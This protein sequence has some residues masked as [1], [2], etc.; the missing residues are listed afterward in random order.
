M[1]SYL[2]PEARTGEQM[3]DSMLLSIL[4]RLE[5]Q[6]LGSEGSELAADRETAQDYFF[7]RAVGRL[8]PPTEPD[9]TDVV[10]RSLMEAVEWTLPEL[11]RIFTAEQP[12][13]FMPVAE[14]DEDAAQQQTAV[15]NHVITQLNPGFLI[16]RTWFH[17]A[18]VERNGYVY[19][20]WDE[21]VTERVENYD[22]LNPDELAVL[23]HKHAQT[24]QKQGEVETISREEYTDD[25]GEVRVNI[26]LRVTEPAGKVCIENIPPERMRVAEDAKGDLQKASY[27]AIVEFPTRTELIEWGFDEEIVNGLA[28]DVEGKQSSQDRNRNTVSDEAETVEIDRSMDQI[29]VVIA[30]VKLDCDGDGKAERRCIWH[31]ASVVLLNEETNYVPFC[32]ISPLPLPHRHIGLSY[33]DLIADLQE[34]GTLLDRQLL[35]NVFGSNHNELGVF[36]QQIVD[37]DDVMIRR[38]NG[39]IRTKCPPGEALMPVTLDLNSEKILVVKQYY[40]SKRE[41]R[42]GV[43]R[44]SQGLD[45]EVL[46]EGTASSFNQGL[47]ASSV[48]REGIARNFAETGVKELMLLVHKLMIEHQDYASEMLLGAG[49]QDQKW[50][51]IDPRQWKSRS[52]MTVKVG[53][54]EHTKAQ[55]RGALSAVGQIQAASAQAG[56]RIV[57]D[58]NAYNLAE[59]TVRA[60]GLPQRS[61]RYFTAPEKMPKQQPQENPLV[62]TSKIDAQTKIATATLKMKGDLMKLAQTASADEKARIQEL[63][64]TLAEFE[65]KYGSQMAGALLEHQ[66][67]Q[68]QQV[69]DLAQGHADRQ[70]RREGLAVQRESAQQRTLPQAVNE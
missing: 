61:N 47:A 27:V 35:D 56:A 52:Q 66:S 18:L 5:S 41:V 70:A 10:D 65:L 28:A 29:R 25:N 51:S 11:L 7:G 2:T 55:E 57:T 63:V 8:A 3:T 46:Q 14:K 38:P 36:A 69:I 4:G 49:T 67:T 26:S 54:G 45:S 34:I 53:L 42:T 58:D 22:G 20:Y 39:V 44:T 16:F 33:Y 37:M 15:V 17:D 62:T 31:T 9:R 23:F 64:L 59:D 19:A 60:F 12:L 48:M 32:S 1:A 30:S 6:S 40:D 50:I 43:G 13:E 68:A 24:I 21:S